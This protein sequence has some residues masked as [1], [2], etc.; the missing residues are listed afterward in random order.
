M[1]RYEQIFLKDRVRPLWLRV[2]DEDETFL[3]GIEVR[4]DGDEVI[5]RLTDPE[6]NRFTQRKRVIDK[7][8]IRVRIPGEI[9]LM[10]G[11][12]VTTTA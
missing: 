2:Q 10:Y 11:E 1:N 3:T 4:K 9:S 8:T 12:L 6:G 5:P 7:S